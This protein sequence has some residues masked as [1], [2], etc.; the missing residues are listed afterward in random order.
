MPI[1]IKRAIPSQA[2]T[3]TQ[4]AIAAKRHWGYPE[5]WIE[6]WSPILTISPESIEKHDTYIAHVNGKPAGFYALSVKENKASLEHLWVLP[7]HIGE[8]I[9]RVLFNHALSFCRESGVLILE[10]ESD[11]NAQGFYER[12]GA[13]KV[14]EN[15]GEVDRQLRVLP[16]LEMVIP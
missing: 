3:L 16:V 14:G 4:I 9:G 1:Q 8:G 7:D 10:I 11:P 15:I 2:K 12:M 6:I 5:R 13:L